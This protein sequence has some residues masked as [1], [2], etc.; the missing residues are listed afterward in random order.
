MYVCLPRIYVLIA[1]NGAVITGGASGI[2]LG[3][4]LAAATFGMIPVLIDT[5]SDALKEA[6]VK[7]RQEV[8]GSDILTIMC[9]VS[10]RSAMFEAAALV[11]KTFPNKQISMV[12]ANAGYGGPAILK[13]SE[14]DLRRQVGLVLVLVV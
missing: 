10:D 12:C 7:I 14:E 2:G 3:L 1:K 6:E 9:D 13:S 11:E 8:G 4:A 5:N